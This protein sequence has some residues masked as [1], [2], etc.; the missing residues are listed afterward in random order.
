MAV[1]LVPFDQAFLERSWNWLQDP[2]I[3]RLTLTPDFTREEQ[4][5]FFDGLPSRSDYR[6]WGVVL[7]GGELIGAAGLKNVTRGSA[8]YWGYIGEKQWWGKGLGGEMLTAVEAEARKLGLP[9][10]VL[11]VVTDNVRAV[12]AYEKS[13]FQ[14][15]RDEAGVLTMSKSLEQRSRSD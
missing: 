12:R 10:L 1:Q 7:A 11:R 4:Q 13:G 3:K 2:E 9:Q 15:A 14:V 5:R 6:I 8:E